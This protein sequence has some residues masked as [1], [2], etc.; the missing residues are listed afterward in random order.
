MTMSKKIISKNISSKIKIPE[1]ESVSILNSFINIIKIKSANSNI[2]IPS[3]GTFV[4]KKT[5]QRVGRNPKTKEEFIISSRSKLT[6]TAS[7]KL[8]KMIN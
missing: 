8:K 3:F 5:P 4:V 1:L 2:K 7:E 6:F